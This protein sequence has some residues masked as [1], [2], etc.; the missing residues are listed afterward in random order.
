MTKNT[1]MVMKTKSQNSRIVMQRGMSLVELTALIVV[2]LLFLGL[3][4]IGARSWKAGSDRAGCVMNISHAQKTVLSVGNLHG[5][6]PGQTL[7]FDLEAWVFVLDRFFN[8]R[9][10]C[11][12]GGAYTTL[13]RT[14]PAYGELFLRCDLAESD[15]HR[16]T[17]R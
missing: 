13:G 4:F 16:P 9:P 17:E 2:L 5:Y 8:S 6:H 14:I 12:G 7:S 1:C 11:R 15:Q 3:S 10:K